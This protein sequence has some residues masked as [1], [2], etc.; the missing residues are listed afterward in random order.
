MDQQTVL[1]EQ[2]HDKSAI[3]ELDFSCHSSGNFPGILAGLKLSLVVTSYQA[4]RLFFVRSNG[5]QIDVNFKNFVRPMGISVTPQQI[6]L[7]TLNQVWR[8]RRSDDA[9]ALLDDPHA[10]ACYVASACHT[11]GLINIHDIAYGN[12]G[13]WVTNSAFSCLA[14]LEPDYSFVPRWKPDFISALA[15]EDRCHLNGMALLDGEPAY[16]TT[17]NQ[18]DTARSWRDGAKDQGTLI[19]IKT[20]EQIFSNLTMPHSPRCYNGYVYFCESG[21]GLVRRYDP[22]TN[23]VVDV[24]KLAGFTRG[25]DFFGPLMFVGLSKTRFS[26]VA[27]P[28]P[29]AQQL[30]ESQSGIWC[31]NLTDHSVVGFVRFEGNIDQIYD[32]AV[33]SGVMYPELLLPDDELSMSVFNFP[34]LSYAPKIK[35]G[36]EYV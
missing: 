15:P 21:H 13:L 3:D 25:M 30:E 32:V 36:I 26:S 22:R 8:F 18:S 28:A 10:D 14:T 31:I 2:D 20:G 24:V 12:K 35:E 33:L 27:E 16:V 29:I 9:L 23:E 17:F 34:P 1:P 11:T 4:H 5:V 19:N 7:G 6:T